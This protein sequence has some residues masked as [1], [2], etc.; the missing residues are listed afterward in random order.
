MVMLTYVVPA[1]VAN[2]AA[3]GCGRVYV[4]EVTI[5]ERKS[6]GKLDAREITHLAASED[7][8]YR[9]GAVTALR[10]SASLAGCTDVKDKQPAIIFKVTA[11]DLMNDKPPFAPLD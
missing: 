8:I 4:I 6:K 3:T 10:G 7:N 2:E 11:F 1:E 9:Q 5:D